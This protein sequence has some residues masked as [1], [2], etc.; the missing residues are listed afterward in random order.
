MATVA[1]VEQVINTRAGFSW[2]GTE[3]TGDSIN[4]HHFVWSPRKVLTVRNATGG[5]LAISFQPSSL[6]L[7]V[8]TAPAKTVS[9]PNG[10]HRMFGPFPSYYANPDNGDRVYVNVAGAMTLKVFEMAEG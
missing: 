3:T 8:F 2:P 6:K 4:G 9:V 5:A 1:I 7:D 10:A